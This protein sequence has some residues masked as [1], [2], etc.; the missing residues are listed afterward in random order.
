MVDPKVQYKGRTVVIL[1]LIGMVMSSLLSLRYADAIYSSLGFDKLTNQLATESPSA[2]QPSS[3]VNTSLTEQDLAKIQTVYKLIKKN[4]VQ[5]VD[6]DKVMTG[7]INGMIDAL[8]DPYTQYMDVTEAKQFEEDVTSSFE[9]IGAEVS[10]EDGKVVIISPIK[11]SPAEKAGLKSKDIIVSV[12]NEKLEGL[13]LG[14]AVLKIRGPKG[15]EVKIEIL[16]EG[17]PSPIIISVTRGEIDVE[18]VYATML[19]NQI[20]N[21]EIRQFSTHTADRF[22]EE[23]AL[24]EGKNI[25]GL[26]IDVRNNPG[27]LLNVVQDIAQQFVPS[28]KTIVKIENR[29]GEIDQAVSKGKA[30]NYPIVVLMNNGSASASEILAGALHDTLNVKLIGEKTFGKGTVQV[31]YESELGDGSNLKITNYKWLTPSGTWIHKNGIQ[32]DIAIE[33]PDYFKI[34][35]ITKEFNLKVNTVS[36]DNKNLQLMLKALNYPVDR[37]DGYFSDATYQA[38]K[39]F[40]QKQ[41]LPSTGEVD[42]KTASKLETE[43][44]LKIRDPQNDLQ[45]KAA[46]AEI[47]KEINP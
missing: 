28:G 1:I 25:K 44:I 10:L 47:R 41:G 39:A 8:D 21:I 13:T 17:V 9:G 24:L 2:T 30:K 11:N 19:D 6:H 27:G 32:P 22:K 20:G 43:T 26:I 15:T 34:S 16:R 46:I 18:T 14:Q 23:L 31:T 35:M 40:Q 37:V 45:L 36:E 7:A 3:Q 12:N 5:D 4:Y 38:V 33:Q 29:N 42:A